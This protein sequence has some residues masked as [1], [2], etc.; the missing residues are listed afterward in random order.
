VLW[1]YWFT[2]MQEKRTTGLWW[3]RQM[4]GLYAPTLALT[5]D[6]R[7]SVLEWPNVRPRD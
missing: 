6:G 2:T 7:I 4:L 3:R 5:A 1:Q